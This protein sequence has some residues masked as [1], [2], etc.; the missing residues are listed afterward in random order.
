[1]PEQGRPSLIQMQKLDVY[2]QRNTWFNNSRY[3][4][5]LKASVCLVGEEGRVWKIDKGERV[6]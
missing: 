5:F 4:F 6:Q 1:M 2:I 3:Y